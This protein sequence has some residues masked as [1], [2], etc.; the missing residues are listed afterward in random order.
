VYPGLAMVEEL[1]SDDSGYIW[2][3]LVLAVLGVSVSSLTPVSLCC[4]R[5]PGRPV[6]LSVADILGGFQNLGL[7]SGM[8]TYDLLF[9]MQGNFWEAFRLFGL[10]PCMKQNLLESFRLWG[11]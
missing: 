6:T 1:E 2:L 5:S 8:Y 4:C 9:W 3:Y 10:L 7:Q 11:F